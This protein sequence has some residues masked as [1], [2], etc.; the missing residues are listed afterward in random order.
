MFIDLPGN[1]EGIGKAAYH[2]FE[3]S[4]GW[5]ERSNCSPIPPDFTITLSSESQAGGEKASV[6]ENTAQSAKL[7][8]WTPR[9]SDR[10]DSGVVQ[11]RFTNGGTSRLYFPS[12]MTSF[13]KT[14]LGVNRTS[15]CRVSPGFLHALC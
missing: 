7:H 6:L 2:S 14:T 4:E 11:S 8:S 1:D 12:P 3:E 13:S 9:S 5:F 15:T 10:W